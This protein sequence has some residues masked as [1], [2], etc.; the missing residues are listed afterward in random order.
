MD[1]VEC[2]SRDLTVLMIAHRLSTVQRCDRLIRLD[3]GIISV[4]GP[5]R[6]VMFNDF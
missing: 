4:D 6:K 2:L 1:A 5:P 3:Q